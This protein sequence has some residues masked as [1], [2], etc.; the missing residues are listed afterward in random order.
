MQQ[1][2][3]LFLQPDSH[4]DQKPSEGGSKDMMQAIMTAQ[5]IATL[6][7]HHA[8]TGLRVRAILQQRAWNAII[9]QSVAPAEFLSSVQTQ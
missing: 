8:W 7:F 5:A 2:E 6:A 9:P 4:F 3:D 1:P